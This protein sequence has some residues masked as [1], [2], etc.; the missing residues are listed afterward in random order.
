M[1]RARGLGP[2]DGLQKVLEEFSLAAMK[3]QDDIDIDTFGHAFF[4]KRLAYRGKGAGDCSGGGPAAV[5]PPKPTYLSDG[6]DDSE[7]EP[8]ARTLEAPLMWIIH[9]PPL[10][11]ATV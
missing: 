9:P 8:E 10:N 4:A 5:T 11:L 1:Q 6:G 3:Q 2:P 7:D